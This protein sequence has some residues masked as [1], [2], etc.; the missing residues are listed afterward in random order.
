MLAIH[1][2]RNK[3][4]FNKPTTIGMC[5]LD[6]SK[7]LMYDYHYNS[8]KAKYGNRATLCFTDTDSLTYHIKTEDLYK[9]MQAEQDKYDFSDYPSTSPFFS[10]KNTKVIGKFKDELNGV[11]IREFVGLR[12]KMYSNLADNGKVKKTAKGVKKSYMEKNIKHENY[13]AA[14]FDKSQMRQ[15]ATFN[16]IR[17]RN[18]KIQSITVTKVGLCC[19]DDKRYIL[20]DNIHTYAHGHW[21]INK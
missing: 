6:L 10:D 13:K 12:A 5:I 18:H 11:P 21:R 15:S 8:V 9:D 4:L 19:F 3:V 16:M 17:S 1:L 2:K 14:L 20:D 7:T